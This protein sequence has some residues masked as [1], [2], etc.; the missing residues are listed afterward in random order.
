M[1]DR[2]LEPLHDP[3]PRGR[4][5]TAQAVTI[6]L[7]VVGILTA[8]FVIQNTAEAKVEFLFWSAELP[9]A[10]AL[11]LAAA[12]GGTLGFLVEYVR[13]R[14]FRS[15]LRQE[16]RRRLGDGEPEAGPEGQ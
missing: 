15:A 11:I 3:G 12:L 1:R 13:Y 7:L 8:I 10:G 9:L 5:K 6:A 14:Q 2:K 4:P 16:R